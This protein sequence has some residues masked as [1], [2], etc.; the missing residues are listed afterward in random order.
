MTTTAKSLWR[1]GLFRTFGGERLANRLTAMSLG[2]SVGLLRLAMADALRRHTS[3]SPVCTD[4]TLP[5]FDPA[6]RLIPPWLLLF[7]ADRRGR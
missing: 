1:V 7:G 3:A 6:R 5:V 4:A 2:V